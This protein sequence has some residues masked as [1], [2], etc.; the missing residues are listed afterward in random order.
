[1]ESRSIIR[2]LVLDGEIDEE[3]IIAEVDHQLDDVTKLEEW[4]EF[5]REA[6]D[7]EIGKYRRSRVSAR[8][9]WSQS[10][11][12]THTRRRSTSS[13][14]QS[15]REQYL[16]KPVHVP[17]LGRVVRYRDLT[18]EHCDSI[19]KQRFHL[20]FRNLA[21]GEYYEMQARVLRKEKATT[22][23]DLSDDAVNELIDGQPNEEVAL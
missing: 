8:S 6:V 11:V 23:N 14:R 21:W 2:Q 19:A 15:M 3:K 10:D 1:M 12:E 13:Q 18:P 5:L 4:R 22:M 17:D 9:S 7:N 16:N 20:A